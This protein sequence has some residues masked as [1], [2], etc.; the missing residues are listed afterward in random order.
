MEISSCDSSPKFKLVKGGYMELEC[1]G[2]RFSLMALRACS[3]KFQFFE[4]MPL[5]TPSD[6]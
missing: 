4:K 5:T 2:V 1:S 3:L 6:K